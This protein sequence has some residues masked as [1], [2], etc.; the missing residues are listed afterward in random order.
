MYGLCFK[1]YKFLTQHKFC[2]SIICTLRYGPMGLFAV[3]SAYRSCALA[4][5]FWLSKRQKI[6]SI[7]KYRCNRNHPFCPF[8]KKK[9]SKLSR[10]SKKWSLDMWC[11]LKWFTD[12]QYTAC[13]RNTYWCSEDLP[14]TK[15][16]TYKTRKAI[17]KQYRMTNISVAVKH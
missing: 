13:H 12:Y 15:F 5:L 4:L 3:F 8:E 7:L 1:E 10:L 9:K 2:L 11:K 14:S 17:C 16:I 6:R